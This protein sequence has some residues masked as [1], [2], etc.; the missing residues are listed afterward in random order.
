MN[1]CFRQHRVK[2]YVLAVMVIVLLLPLLFSRPWLDFIPKYNEF[3]AYVGDTIGGI[4]APFVGLLS[5]WLV[6]KAF[7]EQIEANK[8]TSDQFVIA[9]SMKTIEFLFDKFENS[10]T[11]FKF[12]KWPNVYSQ[13]QY[14]NFSEFMDL[15]QIPSVFFENSS[16]DDERRMKLFNETS[17]GVELEGKE[18]FFESLVRIIVPI[19]GDFHPKDGKDLDKDLSGL[20]RIFK[21]ASNLV[22]EIDQLEAKFSNSPLVSGKPF[23]VYRDLTE[24]VIRDV[25][26]QEGGFDYEIAKTQHCEACGVD[27][28]L[29]DNFYAALSRI[30]ESLKSQRTTHDT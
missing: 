5:A 10:V 17:K 30:Q 25:V 19:Y 13:S 27:H 4:T 28:V 23:Q 29:P 1:K 22:L 24:Q 15:A 14:R 9:Q 6:Y 16:N 21:Q 8:I 20:T 2:F 11:N 18:A 3:T 7:H 26:F 12:K